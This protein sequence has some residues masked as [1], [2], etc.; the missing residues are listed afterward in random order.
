MAT[1][2]WTLRGTTNTFGTLPAGYGRLRLTWGGYLTAQT[3][4][5]WSV[6]A[7]VTWKN[8]SGQII[9]KQYLDWNRGADYEC[10]FRNCA[11]NYDYG[12]IVF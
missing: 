12:G 11:V 6:D 1:S 7:I 3:A 2:R 10:Y 4:T 8:A 5:M 9:G